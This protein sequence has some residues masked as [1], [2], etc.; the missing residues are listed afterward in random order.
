MH[1]PIPLTRDLVLIGGGH[2][3]ALV[4]RQWA[5]RPLPGV[6]LTVINPGPS[7]PYSGMLPGL[8]AGHYRREQLEIDLVRLAR[9]A[10]ARVVLG[11]ATG[12]D[13]QARLVAV[14]GRAPVFYDI[15]SIDIGIT[16]DLPSLP[17]FTEHAV[18]AK[19]LGAF[20]DRWE[21]FAAAARDGA[22][23]LVIG[24]GVAGV[25]LAMASAHRLRQ[26]GVAAE[27]HLLEASDR[28]LRDIGEGAR[29][30]LLSQLRENG[31]TLHT[32]VAIDRVTATGVIAGG[33]EMPGDLVIGVAG[34][35]PQGWLADT[36]LDLVDGF[37]AVGPDLASVNDPA[38]Y[39]VGDCAHLTHAPRPKAGVFAVREAPVLFDNLRADLIGGRRRP[40]HPQRDYLKLISTGGKR[41]V[42]DKLGL[43]L[44]GDLL[45]RWKD[46]ID[47]KFMAMFHDMPP[48]QARPALPP[49]A[50]QGVAEMLAGHQPP[51]GG[52]AA[53]PGPDVLRGGLCDLPAPGRADVLVGAGDDAAVLGH[54]DG[55][56]VITADHF[57]A[58]VDD[59]YVL[60]QIAAVHA[61]GD[62]W[63]MGA[64]PQAALATLILPRMRDRMQA[65]M[66]RE[67]MA[68]ATQVFRAAGADLVGGHTSVGDELTVG[69]TVTGLHPGRPIGLAGA[70][71]GDALILTKP[72]GSGTI[73]AAEMQGRAHG[74]DVAAALRVMARA[75]GDAAGIL[76]P[77]A[78]AMTDVTGYGLAGHLLTV[79]RASGLGAD[80]ALGAVPLMPGALELAQE[81]V[82]STAY[83][84]NAALG[85][86]LIGAEP[87]DPRTALLFDPQTAGGLLAAV[88]GDQAQ[89]VVERLQQGGDQAAVIGHLAPGAPQI[90]LR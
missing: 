43:R 46:R 61:L 32:G 13:R 88:P 50:A 54:G 33:A 47:R 14:K 17:G 25:E 44:E 23:V 3:H 66:L 90:T 16:S 82:R 48:M 8:I 7:A 45:W 87:G 27:V 79:L 70:Q 78:R 24:A 72:L 59:P 56:Q 40:Y 15:A 77:V 71:A 67:I 30:A 36:G 41:A 73:F 65:E 81:G 20:A 39:A 11:C 86:D 38:I 21:A 12:I 55:A 42:A 74:D 4:L 18:P 49:V 85:R 31:V 69:F 6:R 84:A 26:Q 1:A 83:E 5:M 51:C 53:K 19:P 58:F 80:L 9:A 89:G 64:A 34:A 63:A 2:S 76:A 62:I 60:T 35:R 10:G 52:C 37:V 68:A 28:P 29:R 22:R 57:R 75:Q